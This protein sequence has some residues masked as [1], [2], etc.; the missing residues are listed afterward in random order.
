LVLDPSDPWSAES[1]ADFRVNDAGSK[2]ISLV[3]GDVPVTVE[4]ITTGS[5]AGVYDLKV[6]FKV[7]SLDKSLYVALVLNSIYSIKVVDAKKEVTLFKNV[8]L[9][10]YSSLDGNITAD[11]GDRRVQGRCVIEE[12][13][14][15]IFFEVCLCQ[16]SSFQWVDQNFPKKGTRTTLLVPPHPGYVAATSSNAS[17]GS[18]K[19]PMPCKISSVNVKVGQ[20]VTKGQTLII[21]EAMKMEVW[22]RY[23]H[24]FCYV[25]ILKFL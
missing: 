3:D 24:F 17:A 5:S 7:I 4:L 15:H 13:K 10:N 2:T 19:T 8:T 6:N 22:S 25:M 11:V 18:V 23:Y 16:C 12:D 14:I 9:L 20:A 1:L 21:L